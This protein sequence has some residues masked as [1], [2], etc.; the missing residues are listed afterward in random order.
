MFKNIK[1]KDPNKYIIKKKYLSE[2]L[3][4]YEKIKDPGT[5]TKIFMK[6]NVFQFHL[7]L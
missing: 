6:K 5:N 4:L 1:Y 2:I 3:K 7:I